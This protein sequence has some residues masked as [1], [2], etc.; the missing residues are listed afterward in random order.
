MQTR[1]IFNQ[2]K[3][4]KKLLKNKSKRKRMKS[5]NSRKSFKR[6]NVRCQFKFL[7]MNNKSEKEAIAKLEAQLSST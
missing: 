5:L 4:I 6:N 7:E 3:M 2:K 1:S